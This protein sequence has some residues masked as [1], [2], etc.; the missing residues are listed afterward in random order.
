MSEGVKKRPV[1]RRPIKDQGEKKISIS[2]F[3]RFK[4]G[5]KKATIDGGKNKGREII[6]HPHHLCL[7]RILCAKKTE[8]LEGN[9]W[10]T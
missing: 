4:P 9:W 3:L 1:K 5:L 8:A 7:E 10:E 6:S 2:T